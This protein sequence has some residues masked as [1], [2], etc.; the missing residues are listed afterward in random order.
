VKPVKQARRKLKELQAKTI[1]CGCGCGTQMA[2]VDRYGRS[3]GFLQGHFIRVRLHQSQPER[4]AVEAARADQTIEWCRTR[5]LHALANCEEK[6]VLRTLLSELLTE[7][8]A[9]GRI[10]D[11]DAEVHAGIVRSLTSMGWLTHKPADWPADWKPF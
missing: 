10:H 4:A 9:D 7:R 6:G 8:T 3:R 1:L 11:A 2:T 5:L